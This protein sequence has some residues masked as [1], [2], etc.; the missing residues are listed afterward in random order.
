MTAIAGVHPYA[1]QFPMLTDDELADL[2][3]SIRANGLRQPIVVTPDGL[4]LDGRNRWAACQRAGVK[5]ATMVY[6][7][8]PADCVIDANVRRRHMTTGARAMSAALV[9]A[10]AGRRRDGR[11]IGWSRTSQTSG[12]SSGEREA[13]RQAGVVLDYAPDLAAPV[14]SGEVTLNAAYE[15]AQRARGSRRL[16]DDEDAAR[17]HLEEHAPELVELVADGTHGSYREVA[18]AALLIEDERAGAARSE[19]DHQQQS[20][21]T[22]AHL[23][24][25]V[26]FLAQLDAALGG[27]NRVMDAYDPA[28][29]DATAGADPAG[30]EPD[31][32]RRASHFLAQLAEWA[33]RRNKA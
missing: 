31:S 17:A 33:E 32:L 12:R 18:W 27:V 21:R 11:W 4:V 1:E 26:R 25:T 6:E 8:D 2:A 3:E 20:K 9:L 30:L 10:A 13:L 16:R 19:R 14:V 22:Y 24:G 23:A 29:L 28:A 7:G 15:R 5:P